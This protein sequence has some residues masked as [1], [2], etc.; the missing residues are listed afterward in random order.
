MATSVTREAIRARRLLINVG[1]DL[2]NRRMPLHAPGEAFIP[3]PMTRLWISA[4]HPSRIRAVGSTDQ[5]FGKRYVI[6]GRPAPIEHFRFCKCRCYV[7][8]L[9]LSLLGLYIRCGD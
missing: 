7:H 5:P 1:Y 9:V 6:Q 8:D 2:A 4:L 3:L